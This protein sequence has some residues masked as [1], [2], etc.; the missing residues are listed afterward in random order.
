ME[1]DIIITKVPQSASDL[2]LAEGS[3]CL[4]DIDDKQGKRNR[5]NRFV[6]RQMPTLRLKRL[7]RKEVQKYHK[8]KHTVDV[9]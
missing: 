1:R 5:F 7:Q 9:A 8:Q 6:L 4:I 3:A 2:K